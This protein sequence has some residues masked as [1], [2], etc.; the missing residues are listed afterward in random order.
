[1][2]GR[3]Y[4]LSVLGLWLASMS[5]LVVEKVLPPLMG[6]DPP[7]YDAVLATAERPPDCWKIIW[8][9][10]TIGFAGSKVVSHDDGGRELRSL[11]QFEQVPLD[12]MMSEL[13]GM[14]ATVVRPLLGGPA[15]RLDAQISTQ[16][17]FDQENRLE[18]IDTVLNLAD[19]PELMTIR[20]HVT[21]KASW[22]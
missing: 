9:D 8:K 18:G 3:L 11:V 12:S 6:G 14:W 10:E 13:L 16:V 17:W 1:M 7:D 19:M 2:A 4:T 5:W 15:Y 20:G 21:R 22:T